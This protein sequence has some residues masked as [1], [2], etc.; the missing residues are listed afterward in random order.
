MTLTHINSQAHFT[1]TVQNKYRTRLNINAH[2][3]ESLW[4]DGND[5][6]H[7]TESF[8]KTF[9]NGP[10]G[11]LF[12]FQI[13]ADVFDIFDVF[14]VSNFWGN[15]QLTY[16]SS[17]W[18]KISNIPLYDAMQ[19]SMLLFGK[20]Y[21]A[22]LKEMYALLHKSLISGTVF[23]TEIRIRFSAT[24]TRWF[25]IST[26]PR[27]EG[28]WV[29]YDGIL[30]DITKRKRD[31]IELAMFRKAIEP[32]IKNCTDELNSAKDEL[33]SVKKELERKNVQ[34]HNEILAHMKVVKQ[35]ENFNNSRRLH[36]DV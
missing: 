6:S 25:R 36:Q 12:R 32:L 13:K 22:D 17:S 23:N 24:E 10:N 34:L 8:G 26:Q 11:C 35:L 15:L 7:Q 19:N 21:P 9:P 29:V 3:K 18:E 20:I 4:I 2:Q 33:S 27:Y 5:A 30:L 31:E 1:P 28:E 16:A 14:N